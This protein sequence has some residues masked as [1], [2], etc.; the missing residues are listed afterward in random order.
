MLVNIGS[1]L[2]MTNNVN[3]MGHLL[4]GD[5]GIPMSKVLATNS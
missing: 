3:L 4:K 2:I 1:L 5:N